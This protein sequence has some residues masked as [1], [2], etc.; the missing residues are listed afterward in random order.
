[1]RRQ[2]RDALTRRQQ[3]LRLRSA[4]LRVT[5]AHQA[6]DLKIPLA[7]AD[8]VVT[9]VQWLRQHPLW[10][11]G[12]LALLALKR[13]RRIL[14]WAPRLLGGWQLYLRARDWLGNAATK[15]QQH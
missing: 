13:P 11:L 9:G 8:Q 12:T 7:V 15:P 10:P 1:M 4:E 14:R 2:H 6:Q 3:Q 5:L